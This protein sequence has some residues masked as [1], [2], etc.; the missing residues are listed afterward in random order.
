MVN[1]RPPKTPE[2][3]HIE[4]PP[5]LYKQRHC[6]CCRLLQSPIGCDAT[7]IFVVTLRSSL[8]TKCPPRALKVMLLEDHHEQ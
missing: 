3:P 2:K 6:V 1:S 4:T 7:G 8:G 5:R